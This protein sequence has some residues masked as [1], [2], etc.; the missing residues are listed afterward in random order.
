VEVKRQID[1]YLEPGAQGATIYSAIGLKTRFL[2]EEWW[3]I[4]AEMLPYAREKNFEIGW[5]REIN[6]PDGDAR[7][8][9]LDPP[10]QSLVLQGHPEYR[11]QHLE[12]VE[13]QIAGPGTI[14]IELDRRNDY[15]DCLEYLI[16]LAIKN[17]LLS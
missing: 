5:V 10:D 4:W 11:I 6:N 14:Q 2:S 16:S 8:V 12:I 15:F 9:W 13:R 7:D 1:D 17:Q 3:H